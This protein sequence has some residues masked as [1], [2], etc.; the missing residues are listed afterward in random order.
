MDDNRDDVVA[1]GEMT[2]TELDL[3]YNIFTWDSPGYDELLFREVTA[4][5]LVKVDMTQ[6]LDESSGVNRPG[7][8]GDD[9]G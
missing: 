1:G 4:S 8:S 7:F 3:A 6:D 5:N 2:M 9:W